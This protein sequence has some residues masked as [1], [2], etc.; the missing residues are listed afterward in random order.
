MSISSIGLCLSLLLAIP[1]E[2][3]RLDGNR[4]TGELTSL[5]TSA[6]ALEASTGPVEIPLVERREVLGDESDALRD[7]LSEADRKTRVKMRASVFFA[8][9]I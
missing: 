4:Q 6:L 8:T 5:T 3:T 9:R 2:A 1:V 7:R